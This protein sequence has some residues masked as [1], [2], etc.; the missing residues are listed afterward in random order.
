MP[1]AAWSRPRPPVS[2]CGV[3]R[4]LGRLSFKRRHSLAEIVNLAAERGHE[5]SQVAQMPDVE[6]KRLS[7]GDERVWRGGSPHPA[8]APY[9]PGGAA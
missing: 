6:T 3:K 4:L 9:S 5:L 7:E 2:G 1:Q 8:A